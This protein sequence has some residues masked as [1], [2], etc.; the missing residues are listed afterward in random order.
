MYAYVISYIIARIAD[1]YCFA[2]RQLPFK[3]DN[4]KSIIL[5]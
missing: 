5:H 3:I 1:I 4:L 2:I